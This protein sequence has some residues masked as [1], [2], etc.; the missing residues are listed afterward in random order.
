MNKKEVTEADIRTNFITPN[1]VG[2]RGDKWKL[3]TQLREEVYFTNGRVD[4][5][6][7]VPFAYTSPEELWA[8]YR[9]AK[10]YTYTAFQII[11]RLRK[12]GAKKRILFLVDRNILAD[13]TKTNDERWL[14][15]QESLVD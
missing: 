1:L 3:M 6:L 7:D 4:Y 14:L 13:Q 10:D 5:L 15:C 12:S 8:R 2:T 11:W 9:A